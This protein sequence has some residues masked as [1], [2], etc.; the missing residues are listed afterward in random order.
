MGL[1]IL[2]MGGTRFIGRT[3]VSS[4]IAAG[5]HLTLFHRGLHCEIFPA[6]HHIHADRNEELEQLDAVWDVTG[7][8]SAALP[9]QVE[10]LAAS[11]GSRAGAY[12]F[13]STTAAYP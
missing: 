6:T 3:F 4:A 13:V 2:V 11:L 7:D 5:H 10:S 8:F 1:R 9:G 12:V